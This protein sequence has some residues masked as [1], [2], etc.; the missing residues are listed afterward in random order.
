[1][2]KK[3]LF[4]VLKWFFGILVGL[5]TL[6]TVL[7][8]VYK[9]EICGLVVDE[10]NKHLKSEVHVGEIELTFWGSFP[11]LSIDF[12]QVF[13]QDSYPESTKY[14]TLL[15]SDRIRLKLNPLDI[16]RENY[17]IKS[18]EVDPGVLNLKV[19]QEGV[20]NFDILKKSEEEE[21]DTPFELK[22]EEVYFEGFRFAYL[23][24]ATQQEYRTKLNSTLI[25]GAFSDSRFTASADGD[26]QIIS[27]RSGNIDL[28][29]N[30]PAKLKLSVL[31]DKD[32]SLV[33]IP[34]STVYV[35]DLPFDFNALVLD[36]VF[37]VRLKGKNIAI[38]D[39]ANNLAMKE[40]G[41][42]KK[43]KG[44]GK[45][46]FDL[47]INGT[48]DP[49]Q[50]VSVNCAFGVQNAS[51]SVPSS[52]IQ[53]NE[54]N[55]NGLY[56]NKGGPS[57]EFLQ[58]SDV[59]FRTVAGPFTGHLRITQFAEPLVEGNANGHLDLAVVHA[60]FPIPAI[61]MLKGNVE[62]NAEFKVQNHPNIIG[63]NQ[64]EIQRCTGNLDLLGVD[65]SLEDDKRVFRNVRGAVYLR[66]NEFGLEKVSVE[67][68][69]SDFLLNGV[70]KNL[71][72]YFMQTDKL[73]ANVDIRSRRIN[74]DEDLG[75][76]ER[77][78][79]ILK[80]RRFILPNDIE[81]T[82]Y[83][84]VDKMIYEKHTFEKVK[85]NMSVNG[86][87]LYFD[88]LSLSNGGS[89]LVGSLTIEEQTP[90][91]FRINSQ[92]VSQNIN[93]TRLFREWEDF[94]QDAVKSQNIEGDAQANV[95]FEALFDLRSGIK[96]SSIVARIG[97]QI[98]NGRLRNVES[99][100]SLVASLKSSN[101]SRLVLNKEE[102]KLLGD[103][104]RD[105]RFKRLTNTLVIRDQ[106]LV[107]PTMTIESSAL[108]IT[109]TGQHSFD[110]R[111]D[112]KFGFYLRDLKIQKVTEFGVEAD[113]GT[114]LN[115]FVRMFGDLYNPTIEWDKDS[116]KEH[117][118]AYNQKEKEDLKA[119]LKQ[120]FGLFKRDTTV[121]RYVKTN[122]ARESIEL[123][124][125]PKEELNP[126]I[127]ERTPVKED[128]KPEIFEKWRKEKA[129]QKKQEIDLDD[130]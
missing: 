18:L 57:K 3:R 86:R 21:E 44:K 16:W 46:L 28:I 55:L 85:A 80:E 123:E 130:L 22:L 128:K 12:N 78:E 36:S 100:N 26:L 92:V 115:V 54:L 29:Q 59:R 73:I 93:F 97:L 56:S 116:R 87:K 41:E 91:I 53:L 70:F 83:L 99:F 82:L 63:G 6:I 9:D 7:L 88:K 30:K 64:L 108:D 11:N 101:V 13:I 67:L 37:N 66:D 113:D 120:E 60:L 74:I 17:T 71:V 2:L 14:D 107:I 69:S 24:A 104:L 10:L 81:G 15:Y 118:K 52:G 114:G 8:Y 50:P 90:E 72:P 39:A 65:L 98:D 1:M 75:S 35:A 77:E 119:I 117:T 61:E 45:F 95:E 106:M 125:D 31:V 68:G 96:P 129:V 112:Y 33:R 127:D 109:M 48:N 40:I 19:N 102:I 94:K 76:E 121:R 110:N 23:N 5:V 4:R 124:F 25:E 103:K 27:A 34:T 20:N 62:L 111:I 126:L 58:M 49:I 51:L 38:Q 84:D 43:S 122:A 105:L 47:N 42:V 79:K 32:S 89:D